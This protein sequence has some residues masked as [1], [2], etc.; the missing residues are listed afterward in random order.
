L[1]AFITKVGF[2]TATPGTWILRVVGA[3]IPVEQSEAVTLNGQPVLVNGTP[4]IHLKA[5]AIDDI[6]ILCHYA[7]A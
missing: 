5:G 7:V 2:K 6:A 1:S 4:V 3:E